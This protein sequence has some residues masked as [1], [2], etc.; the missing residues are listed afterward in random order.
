VNDA[1]DDAFAFLA[2]A[3]DVKGCE[4]R[5]TRLK[6]LSEQ[7][8]AE[9]AKLDLDRAEHTRI[10]GA[11]R[12]A[13]DERERKLRDREVA[14]AIAERGLIAREKA[15]ADVRPPRFFDD[16][17]LEPGGRSYSGLTREAS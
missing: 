7:V 11:E 5:I 1:F 14:V 15:I 16:P 13:A 2:A 12:A 8:A 6:N 10:T 3:A 4:A 17:N 9:Q